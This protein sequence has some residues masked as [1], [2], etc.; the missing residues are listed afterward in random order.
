[1]PCL[2][3]RAL[4]QGEDAP[5]E[6][7]L[8]GALFFR[9]ARDLRQVHAARAL[10][11]ARI[12][13]RRVAAQYGVRQ[14]GAL[15]RRA[16]VE[17]GERAQAGHRRREA[18]G[19]ARVGGGETHQRRAHGVR[20]ARELRALQRQHA[21]EAGQEGLQALRRHLAPARAH[22]RRRR[23]NHQGAAPDGAQAR[24]AAEALRRG[25]ALALDEIGV[26]E[27]PLGRRAAAGLRRLPLAA[28]P[29]ERARHGPALPR[30]ARAAAR[31]AAPR[32]VG[33]EGGEPLQR[34]IFS[35]SAHGH[36]L[37]PPFCRC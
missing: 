3:G 8:A 22:Q 35:I 25:Q 24:R 6:L 19:V 11:H 23:V 13:A 33:G 27:Q 4:R 14:V 17:R 26:V 5:R 21:L 1:M 32:G 10:V 16:Q 2:A 12:D 36:G 29:R 34:Y 20:K 7:L 31:E 30:P 9:Q 28:Q 37:H 15:Q 18:A